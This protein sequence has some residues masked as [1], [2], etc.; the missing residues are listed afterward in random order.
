VKSSHA[1]RRYAES[2][3]ADHSTAVDRHLRSDIR[4]GVGG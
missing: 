2:L 1:E 3:S 4:L